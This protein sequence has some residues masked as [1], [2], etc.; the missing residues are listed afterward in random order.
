MKVSSRAR[1]D[2]VYALIAIG[3]SILVA[4][5]EGLLAVLNLHFATIVAN[6]MF[7]GMGIFVIGFSFYL[8]YRKRDECNNGS[9]I[10]KLLSLAHKE[11][12]EL[13]N[14]LQRIE[15][16]LNEVKEP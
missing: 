11:I 5:Y 13:K 3:L 15:N 12:E 4:G 2:S 6:A 8:F 10:K 1:A 7:M 14:T 16:V 9:E